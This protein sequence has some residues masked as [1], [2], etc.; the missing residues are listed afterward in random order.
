MPATDRPAST[1]HKTGTPPAEIDVAV[2]GGGVAGLFCCLQLFNRYSSAGTDEP[3]KTIALFEGSSRL[4][5][6]IESWRI[7]PRRYDAIRSKFVK[8]SPGKK[9]EPYPT[10]KH[11]RPVRED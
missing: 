11:P 6:R 5:G 1:D 7:D 4:G 2:V 9:S 8:S 10:Q 3:L